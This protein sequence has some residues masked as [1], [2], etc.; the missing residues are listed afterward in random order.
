MRLWS[1]HPQYLDSKGLVALWRE[2]LLAQACLA[3]KTKGY[4][5]HPQLYRFKKVKNPLALIS[6]Y[7][8]DVLKE[9]QFRQYHLINLKLLLSLLLK[10]WN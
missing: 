1:I 8:H 5:H 4:H 3:K 10:K 9:A 6:A 7:L 2:A